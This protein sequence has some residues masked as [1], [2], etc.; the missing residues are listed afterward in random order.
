M[1]GAHFHINDLQKNLDLMKQNLADPDIA[2]TYDINFHVLIAEASGNQFLTELTNGLRDSL[3]RVMA[4]T[5]AI[6]S[7][8]PYTVTYH[9]KILESI[10]K[11]DPDAAAK[12]MDEHL[13]KVED[14]VK[15]SGIYY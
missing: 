2:S 13:K 1:E 10:A 7:L 14:E 15:K 12:F 5:T 6:I 3:R 8:R 9:E 11:Q 4:K